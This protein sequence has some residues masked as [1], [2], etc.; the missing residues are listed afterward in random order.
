VAS[1][2]FE[3]TTLAVALHALLAG[4]LTFAGRIERGAADLNLTVEA[5]L[6]P[7]VLEVTGA[8][9]TRVPQSDDRTGVTRNRLFASFTRNVSGLLVL[10]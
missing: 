5:A 2:S 3:D 6:G 10:A 4:D 8:G 9:F 1:P 7:V